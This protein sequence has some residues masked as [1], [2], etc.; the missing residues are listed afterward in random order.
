[1]WFGTGQHS[2][3]ERDITPN[4]M[5][6]V[7]VHIAAVIYQSSSSGLIRKVSTQ[8]WVMWWTGFMWMR[9]PDQTIRPQ[10]LTRTINGDRGKG[11]RG[12]YT[13]TPENGRT[14]W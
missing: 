9:N 5:R 7:R 1:M 12:I 10:V 11:G 8:S 14:D 13:F 3:G 2:T 4:A 6:T